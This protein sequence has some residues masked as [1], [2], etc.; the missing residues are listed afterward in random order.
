ML[1]GVWKQQMT[2]FVLSSIISCSRRDAERRGQLCHDVT[3]GVK[4]DRLFSRATNCWWKPDGTRAER[5][6]HDWHSNHVCLTK[7]RG[8]LTRHSARAPFSWL[9]CPLI[10]DCFSLNL[11]KSSM[12]DES[13]PLQPRPPAPQTWEE[14]RI[15]S[16]SMQSMAKTA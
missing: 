16:A 10:W 6:T 15:L 11:L 13:L 8:V 5:L 2:A 1:G 9:R 7:I 3:P 14:G 12:W 4:E